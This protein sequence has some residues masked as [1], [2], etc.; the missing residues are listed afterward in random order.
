MVASTLLTVVVTALVMAFLN[1]Y[2]A[3]S[4]KVEGEV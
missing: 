2:T 1:K 3:K 4:Q